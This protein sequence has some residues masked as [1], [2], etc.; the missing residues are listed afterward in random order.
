MQAWYVCLLQGA[1]QLQG[2]SDFA[3]MHCCPCGGCCNR[4]TC[5]QYVLQAKARYKQ[6]VL[7]LAKELG[8]LQRRNVQ[9]SK[10]GS[11]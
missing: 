4:L 8:T 5:L 11:E 6:Q 2:V 9:V 1:S 3:G 7:V 10:P